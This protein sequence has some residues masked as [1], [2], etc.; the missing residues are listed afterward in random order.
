MIKGMAEST[1]TLDRLLDPIAE[2]LT[3]DV[4]RRIADL[5]LDDHTKARLEELRTKANE[6][7]LSSGDRVEY[8]EIIDAL[9]LISILRAKAKEVLGK[10]AS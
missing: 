7:S 10:L 3:P 8:E 4:A 1:S 9:D 6:G 5:G 2:C